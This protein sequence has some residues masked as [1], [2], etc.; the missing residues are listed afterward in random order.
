MNLSWLKPRKKIVGT[1]ADLKRGDKFRYN[2]ATLYEE[3][4][5]IVEPSDIQADHTHIICDNITLH[6]HND[7]KIL[8][9]RKI[10]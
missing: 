7:T 9:F 10:A 4:A 8:I 3:T 1:V 6:L 5:L 2:G